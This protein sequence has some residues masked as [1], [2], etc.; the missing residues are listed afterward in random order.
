LI[1][2][3]LVFSGLEGR[4]RGEGESLE[5]PDCRGN[6]ARRMLSDVFSCSCFVKIRDLPGIAMRPAISLREAMPRLLFFGSRFISS[7]SHAN[8]AFSR[9]RACLPVL[10]DRTCT[11]L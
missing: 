7:S 10:G 9:R 11:G 8:V 3:F 4:S 1:A 2:S 5:A 6:Q